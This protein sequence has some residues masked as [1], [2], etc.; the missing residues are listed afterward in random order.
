ALIGR[1]DR[2]VAGA[3][4]ATGPEHAR[5][6][7]ED[8]GLA[9]GVHEDPID[10]VGPGQGEHVARDGLALVLEQAPGVRAEQLLDLSQLHGGY[11]RPTRRKVN[12]AAI[13]PARTPSS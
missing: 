1:Q 8:R 11:F 6:V 7:A 4:Q 9:V 12:W 2:Q 10:V 13:S 5:Q 3:S